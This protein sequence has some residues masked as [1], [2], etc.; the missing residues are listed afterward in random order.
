MGRNIG[1]QKQWLGPTTVFCVG[2]RRAWR[3]V[4]SM[5]RVVGAATTRVGFG[6][7]PHHPLGR[8]PVAS[9][10]GSPGHVKSSSSAEQKKAEKLLEL[11]A[12]RVQ[13]TAP[14]PR[15]AAS[16]AVRS[17][18]SLS[19]SPSLRLPH[20]RRRRA[21]ITTPT[22]STRAAPTTTPSP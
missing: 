20:A 5:F 9:P 6:T 16:S 14:S 1:P 22:P 17:P 7:D 4:K 18:L 13:T 11:E 3:P 15:R 19:L 2:C 12:T 10:S 8:S 21:C